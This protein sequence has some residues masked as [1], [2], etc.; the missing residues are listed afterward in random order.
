MARLFGKL[1]VEVEE[2]EKQENQ[3]NDWMKQSN[4]KRNGIAEK[5]F[6]IG[7]YGLS[8]GPKISK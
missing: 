1:V 6:E 7:Y 5:C 8:Y 4:K 2:T 3:S